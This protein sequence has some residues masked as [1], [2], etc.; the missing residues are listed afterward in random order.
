MTTEA[1]AMV[2]T[3]QGQPFE[4]K[5][6]QLNNIGINEVLVRIVYTTICTSDLHV[7]T[8]KHSSNHPCILGHEIIGEIVSKGKKINID[9]NGHLL[10]KGDLITWSLY[11]HDTKKDR[12]KKGQAAKSETLYHYPDNSTSAQ[13]EL[14]GG[15]ATHCV[16]KKG[17]IIFKLPSFLSPKQAAPLN[18]AHA[19]IAAALR[20]TGYLKDKN[21]LITGTGILGLSASAMA[22]EGGARHV[23]V[24]DNHQERLE[25]AK[26]FGANKLIDS[27]LSTSEIKSAFLFR[28]KIDVVIDTSGNPSFMEKGLELLST[29]GTAVWVGSSYEQMA[30]PINAELIQKHLLTVKGLQHYTPNDLGFAMDFVANHHAQYP[31]EL[32]VGQEFYLEELCSA[33]QTANSEKHYRVGVKQ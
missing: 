21:V 1:R 4:N 10:S 32:L 7:Y 2:F 28:E 27:R 20:L 25:F 31:F 5:P 16:L 3:A 29:A 9:Y 11:T 6:I 12:S 23:M 13:N 33:F 15:F 17:T 8:G 19:T 26:R 18:C 22:K 14:Y 30:T 24:M